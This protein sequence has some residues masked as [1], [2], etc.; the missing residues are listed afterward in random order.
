MAQEAAPA[1]YLQLCQQRRRRPF[2]A[3]VLSCEELP[4]RRRNPARPAVAAA[5]AKAGGRLGP[6]SAGVAAA[7][8]GGTLSQQNDEA[9]R[10]ASRCLWRASFTTVPWML[11]SLTGWCRSGPMLH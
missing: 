5:Q 8:R 11:R 4:P 7:R 2:R 9:I 3:A 6:C 1:W 10:D